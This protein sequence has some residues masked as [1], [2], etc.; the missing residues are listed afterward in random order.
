MDSKEKALEHACESF[1]LLREAGLSEQF[2]PL[3]LSVAD[4]NRGTF[5]GSFGGETGC[6]L[7]IENTGE[8]LTPVS[9]R[10]GTRRHQ[11][12]WARVI[13]SFVSGWRV[14]CGDDDNYQILL[15][16][17]DVSRLKDLLRTLL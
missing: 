14:F 10:F 5:F 7:E 9:I 4:A 6:F 8:S 2:V 16:P 15:A 1:R 12:F 17:D 13:Q 11:S 3:V